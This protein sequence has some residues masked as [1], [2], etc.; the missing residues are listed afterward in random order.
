M[1][2][3]KKTTKSTYKA[4][5]QTPTVEKLIGMFN[6]MQTPLTDMYFNQKVQC[7]KESPGFTNIRKHK[8]KINLECSF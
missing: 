2:W 8:I 3:W 7:V 6:V 5:K 1:I 4:D